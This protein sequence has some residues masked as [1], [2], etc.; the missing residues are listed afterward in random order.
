M[1]LLKDLP[2]GI[3]GLVLAL[4]VYFAVFGAKRLGLV[5]TGD[6]ARLANVLLSGFFAVAQQDMTGVEQGLTALI[7]SLVSAGI[8]RLSQYLQTKST[9]PVSED[10]SG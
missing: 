10:Q 7:A 3:V 1:E 8:Y 4:V 9:P 5:I 6:H 2:V